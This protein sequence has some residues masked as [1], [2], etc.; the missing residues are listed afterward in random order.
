MEK[1]IPEK[2]NHRILQPLSKNN[3]KN[4]SIIAK[5]SSIC[6][7][8]INVYVNNIKEY[9]LL[10]DVCECSSLLI[11]ENNW[12]F[13]KGNVKLR[14]KNNIALSLS[15]GQLIKIDLGKDYDVESGL[16]HYGLVLKV[17]KDKVLVI[18]MTTAQKQIDVSFHPVEN[19]N[20][21]FH[22]RKGLLSEGFTKPVA[23][24]INDIRCISIGR[25]LP[26]DKVD[27]INISAYNDIREHVLRY[28]FS[29][30]FKS[31]DQIIKNLVEENNKLKE[32]V[33][34]FHIGT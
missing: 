27:I 26:Y 28:Y 34:K 7:E 5:D 22:L 6:V 18:P 1:F 13:R 33:K 21:K 30:I 2:I 20:G 3:K 19:K 29:D 12:F 11:S 15:I 32:E 8:N 14:G 10:T 23:L 9:L 17:L 31:K 16:I 4:H 24:Y 25:L